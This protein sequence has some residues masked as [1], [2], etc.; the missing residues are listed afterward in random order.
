VAVA[1]DPDDL[2][3]LLVEEAIAVN[4]R[5]RRVNARPSMSE[6]APRPPHSTGVAGLASLWGIKPE[7][8]DGIRRG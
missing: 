2:A 8:A 6:V 1:L 4:C 7:D 5:S 3:A